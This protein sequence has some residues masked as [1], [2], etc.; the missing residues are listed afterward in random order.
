MVYV[1]LR[2]V[3][4]Y[5]SDEQ[6][7]FSFAHCIRSESQHDIG[8]GGSDA[9]KRTA[10]GFTHRP[11]SV[12]GAGARRLGS[13]VGPGG[14]SRTGRVGGRESGRNNRG[15][16]GEGN[17][18]SAF[19][20]LVINTSN[21]WSQVGALNVSGEIEQFNPR[22]RARE[23]LGRGKVRALSINNDGVPKGV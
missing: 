2:N 3:N 16:G 14:G 12:I 20:N 7:S 21:E 6:Y 18:G 19:F 22:D 5:R 11:T 8:Q 10:N 9:Q 23:V 17:G 15:S 1:E 4:N 13:A